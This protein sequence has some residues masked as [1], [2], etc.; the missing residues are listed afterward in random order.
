MNK[1][2]MILA[3]LVVAGAVVLLI[4]FGSDPSKGDV[5]TTPTPTVTP[6]PEATPIDPADVVQVDTTQ[7]GGT[8]TVNGHSQKQ[9]LT[10]SKYE[11]VYVNGSGSVAT[12]KGP[13]RQIMVNGDKNQIT[14]DAVTEFVFNGTDNQVTYSRFVNGKVPSVVENMAGNDVQ[15]VPSTSPAKDTAKPKSK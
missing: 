9:T 12:I 14:T 3:V 8:L 10:C 15:K 13:C 1:I 5:K 11:R 6:T 7:D 4:S 2:L